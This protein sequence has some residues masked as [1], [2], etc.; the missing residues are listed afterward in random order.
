MSRKRVRVGQLPQKGKKP[1]EVAYATGVARQTVYVWKKVLDVGGMAALGRP[2]RLQYL[3]SL[4]GQIQIVFLPPYAPELNP[5]E[6]LWAWIK[7]HA[8]ANDCPD[9]LRE[10]KTMARNKLKSVQKRPGIITACWKQA[11][12]W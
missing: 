8:L 9:N 10:L 12:L 2:A 5:V 3:D 6:Y 7:R 1:A 4:D 11:T